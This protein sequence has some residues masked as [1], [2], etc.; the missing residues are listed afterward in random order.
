MYRTVRTVI[1][2]DTTFER[3]MQNNA[4]LANAVS[5]DASSGVGS[6]LTGQS[7][8]LLLVR[9]LGRNDGGEIRGQDGD[10]ESHTQERSVVRKRA[11]WT[12]KGR[13]LERLRSAAP[14]LCPLSCR[15]EQPGASILPFCASQR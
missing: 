7:I 11:P 9:M 8:I 13:R 10:F 14:V 6:A 12:N 4:Q 5:I 3:G 2:S 15:P 1:S